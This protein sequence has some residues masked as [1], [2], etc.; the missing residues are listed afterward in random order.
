V[1][2]AQIYGQA[3]AA[4]KFPVRILPNLGPRELVDPALMNGLLQLVPEYA[5]SVLEFISLGH[6]SPTAD[7]ETVNRTLAKSLTGRG[8]LAA[9][10]GR[11]AKQQRHRGDRSDRGPL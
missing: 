10:P 7:V 11:R 1:L 9:H 5:G 8:L 3:L 6:L 2:L 4:K